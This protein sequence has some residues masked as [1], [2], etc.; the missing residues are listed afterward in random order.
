MKPQPVDAIQSTIAVGDI[1]GF[2][3]SSYLKIGRVEKICNKIIKVSVLRY[4]WL[5]HCQPERVIKLVPTPELTMY[6]LR[7]K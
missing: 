7:A 1:V 5:F 6:F 3:R 2:G 4:P